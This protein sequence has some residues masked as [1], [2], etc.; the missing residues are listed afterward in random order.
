MR[1]ASTSFRMISLGG[2]SLCL[3]LICLSAKGVVTL[4]EN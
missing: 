3:R 1:L 4:R 2:G